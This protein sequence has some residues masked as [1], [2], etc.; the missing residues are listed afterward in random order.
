LLFAA[1]RQDRRLIAGMLWLP[2]VAAYCVV[3]LPWFVA[4]QLRNPEFFRI[5]ILEHNL[6]RFGTNL[7][8]HQQPFWY[9]LP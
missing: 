6:A 9:F 8:R 7:Y 1:V 3:T 4:V 2:G 5:F